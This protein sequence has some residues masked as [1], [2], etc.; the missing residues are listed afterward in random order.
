MTTRPEATHP[1]ARRATGV[2]LTGVAAW[3]A[4]TALSVAG[5]AYSPAWVVSLAV[6]GAAWAGARVLTRDIAERRAH[7][8]D[9]YELAQRN[10]ARNAGYVAALVAAL[11]LYVVLA[12]AGQLAERGHDQLLLQAHQLVLAAFLPAAAG[13]SFLVAWRL[14][15]QA[16]PGE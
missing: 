5:E 11:V 16:D 14:R 3:L 9:E 6:L 4:L 15:H 1:A 7:E 10:V 2:V 12:V 13:P 8:V